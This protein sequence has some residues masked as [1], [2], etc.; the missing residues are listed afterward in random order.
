MQD[1][2]NNFLN[3]TTCMSLFT[4]NYESAVNVEN[5]LKTDGNLIKLFNAYRLGN[6]NRDTFLEKNIDDSLIYGLF[7]PVINAPYFER[8]VAQN[9]K[10]KVLVAFL[11]EQHIATQMWSAYFEYVESQYLF[12][13]KSVQSLK[14][15][16]THEHLQPVLERCTNRNYL[17][18]NH[19]VLDDYDETY[20]LAPKVASA[21]ANIIPR[22][23]IIDNVKGDGDCFFT[24]IYNQ[25]KDNVSN[26][27]SFNARALRKNLQDYCTQN[28][29]DFVEH[30]VFIWSEMYRSDKK[31]QEWAFF[32]PYAHLTNIR[33]IG[34]LMLHDK[35]F[36]SKSFYAEVF[37][38]N[39]TVDY[40]NQ[41]LSR[42]LMIIVIDVE[43]EPV[44]ILGSTTELGK[45]DLYLFILRNH[46]HYS[47][48]EIKD[49][50]LFMKK[51]L[52]KLNF[53]FLE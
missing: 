27:E 31:S 9:I 52:P 1:A 25:F 3:L 34:K 22:E 43:T 8:I 11:I 20:K 19:F 47:S 6:F 4:S 7:Y 13:P 21:F 23:I 15:R 46:E 36:M 49:Q 29:D 53:K 24:S 39:I 38:I 45:E 5:V 12:T 10:K 42:K 18:S 51:T 17:Y 28:F 30:T 41:L 26:P 50:R 44:P 33:H 40:I 48:I 16:I 32:R 14:K 35:M 2:R 37:S